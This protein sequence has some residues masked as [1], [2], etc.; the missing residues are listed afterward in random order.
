[1]NNNNDKLTALKS[2]VEEQMNRKNNLYSFIL[3]QGLFFELRDYELTHDMSSAGCNKIV[4]LDPL[5]EAQIELETE[6]NIKNNLYSYIINCG[7]YTKLKE[8]NCIHSLESPDDRIHTL[9]GIVRSDF[10]KA[11]R[12]DNIVK[13]LN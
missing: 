2:Q 11:K 10:L 13:R 3:N 7:L 9:A 8:Y 5:E 6:R 12:S 1:M 4:P